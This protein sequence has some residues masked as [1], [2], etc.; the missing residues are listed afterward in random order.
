MAQVLV[1]LVFTDIIPAG[2]PLHGTTGRI[3]RE[4]VSR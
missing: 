1:T 4:W 2:M 3:V